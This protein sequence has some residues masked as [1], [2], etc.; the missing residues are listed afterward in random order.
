MG[1]HDLTVDDV[2]QIIEGIEHFIIKNDRDVAA[3]WRPYIAKLEA[4]RDRIA[5]RARD[6]EE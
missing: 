4:L 3:I 1:D 6:A 2:D 5:G